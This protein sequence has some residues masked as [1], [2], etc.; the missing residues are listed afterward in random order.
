MWSTSK[1]YRATRRAIQVT[2]NGSVFVVG[3]FRI[4]GAK[5]CAK[6]A[7]ERYVAV[8]R[9][10]LSLQMVTL[11]V[12]SDKLYFPVSWRHCTHYSKECGNCS[13]Y[14]PSVKSRVG[15]I[16]WT[17]LSPKLAV[18][19]CCLWGYLEDRVYHSRSYTIVKVKRDIQEV[20]TTIRQD[21]LHRVLKAF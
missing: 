6:V 7:A 20:I 11:C 16:L 4:V 5:R 21:L 19:N 13:Q 14:V 3:A 18:P 12:Q 1:L 10:I 2:Q 9:N 15:G 17:I 8:L